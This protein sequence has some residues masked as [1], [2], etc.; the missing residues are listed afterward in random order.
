MIEAPDLSLAALA[1]LLFVFGAA[2]VGVL[3]E[4]FWPRDSRHP[5]QVAVALV[6][7]LGGLVCTLLLAG[8]R[9]GHRRGRA[10]RRR[11]RALP[12]GDHRRARRA[13]A[14]A[15][16][17]AG[18]RPGAVGV[19]DVGRRPGGQPPRPRARHL[20]AGADRGLPAGDLRHRRHDAVRRAQRPADHVRRARGAQ[21]AAVPDQRA[22]PPAPAALAGGGGQ[23]LPARRLRLGLLP[24]RPGAGLRRHRQRP[25]ARHPRGRPRRGQRHPARARARAAHRRPAVQGQ[26][27]A[28]PHLDAGRLPG[29]ADPG[30]RLHGGLHEGR[31][32]RGDPAAALRRLRHRRVD[33]AAA[34]LRGRDRLHG[35]RRRHGA[36]PDRPQADARLLLDR[37]RRVPPHRR[38][39]SRRRRRGLRPGGHDVLPARP[40]GSRRSAS[41]PS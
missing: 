38:S 31:R 37:A 8:T 13:R 12:A 40:T 11:R 17:R 3:I 35:R 36:H 32:V 23:V 16:R 34:D 1:P 2:C 39:R 28:V 4:A 14:A 18:A 5:V 20:R 6:G 27:R 29:G 24:L 15:V 26:R 30:H 21:P 7:T 19:R 22:G 41:S 25:P 10:R 9:R 33:V